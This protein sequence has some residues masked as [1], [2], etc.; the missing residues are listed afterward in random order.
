[1]SGEELKVECDPKLAELKDVLIFEPNSSGIYAEANI[2]AKAGNVFGKTKIKAYIE[3]ET[4]FTELEI[5]ELAQS[6][7]PNLRMEL[8]GRDNPPNRVDTLLETGTLVVRIYGK[9]KSL[10]E[11]LGAYSQK[12]FKY[13]NTPQ[14]RAS[15]AEIVAQQLA[16]YVVERESEMYPDRFGD[17][18]KYFF[19]QQQLIADL[20]IVAQVGLI[21]E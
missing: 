9:H 8:N 21:Q 7:I 15:I 5:R 2:F 14:A 4:A 1:M 11:V 19:R 13:E 18:A 16:Q 3:N 6:K 12:G 20:I 10:K 17:A